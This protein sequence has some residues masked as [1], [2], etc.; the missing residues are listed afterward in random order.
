M[1]FKRTLEPVLVDAINNKGK[2]SILL[3]A[4]QTGKTSLH[5]KKYY[6]SLY[7]IMKLLNQLPI[8]LTAK[9]ELNFREL[10]P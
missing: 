2:I 7:Q 6:S 9:A 5:T 8:L 1:Y 3:G 4:R 10:F